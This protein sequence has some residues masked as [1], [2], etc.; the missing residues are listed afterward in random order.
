MMTLTLF[1]WPQSPHIEHIIIIY[2][3]EV[4]IERQYYYRRESAYWKVRI[5]NLG[6]RNQVRDICWSTS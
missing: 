5:N 3:V 1:H 2:Q 6:T 4:E